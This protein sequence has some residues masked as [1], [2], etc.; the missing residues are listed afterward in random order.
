MKKILLILISIFLL[1]ACS[2]SNKPTSKVKD[3]LNQYK[4]LTENVKLDLESKVASEN[5]FD[6]DKQKYKDLLI[7]QYKSMN[8]EIIGEKIN[9]DKA[10]VNVKI[11][12]L[13]Y[14]KAQKE[15]DEYLQDNLTEF[16][17][18]NQVFNDKLFNA[19]KIKK[20]SEIKD[21]TD[22]DIVFYL[23]KV[24]GQWQVEEPD[25]ITFEKLHG[26]YDNT[27]DD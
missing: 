9:D 11:T 13:D 6:E 18:E 14:F 7:K 3:Y 15:S 20:M 16:Y 21:S 22:Y 10:T 25:R 5:L 4:N 19:Y 1:S 8:Y 23:K 2:L 26:L 17:D 24:N 27:S 12:V